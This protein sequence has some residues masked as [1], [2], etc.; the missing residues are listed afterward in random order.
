[1]SAELQ[2]HQEGY[3]G[4]YPGKQPKIDDTQIQIAIDVLKAYADGALSTD[5]CDELDAAIQKAFDVLVDEWTAHD[6]D[7]VDV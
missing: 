2:Q 6:P 3:H 7:G 1:M 5:L 4:W